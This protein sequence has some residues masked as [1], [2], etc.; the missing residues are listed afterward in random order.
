MEKKENYLPTLNLDLKGIHLKHLREVLLMST[1]K[2]SSNFENLTAHCSNYA[3]Y[4]FELM[5]ILVSHF[6]SSA[7]EM[8]AMDGRDSREEERETDGKEK[9]WMTVQK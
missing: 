5:S 1:N 7:R 6:V 3:E 9:R 2:F 4:S 8:E